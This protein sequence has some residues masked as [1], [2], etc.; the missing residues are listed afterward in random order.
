VI[1]KSLELSKA[2]FMKKL[3]Y[4]ALQVLKLLMKGDDARESS[5]ADETEVLIVC[6]QAIIVSDSRGDD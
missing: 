2:Q 4:R 6:W 5:S 1:I 3:I